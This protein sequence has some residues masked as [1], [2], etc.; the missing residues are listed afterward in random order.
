MVSIVIS[1]GHGQK[2][3]GASA[4]PQPPYLDEVN[5]ARKVVDRVGELLR[6]AGHSVKTYHENTATSVNQNL[7]NI[8]NYHNAQSRDRD[9]SVH[10]NAYSKT[11]KPMGTE[12]LY[13]TQSALADQVS[14]AMAGAG[15]FIN[16][17]PKK[18]TDLYFLNNT[19]KPSI[20]LEVCFV[21]SSADGDLYRANFDNLCR[22]IA[23]SCASIKLPGEEP[24]PIEP[25]PEPELPPVTGDH[26]AD[27]NISASKGTPG[28]EINGESVV[29]ASGSGGTVQMTLTLKGDVVVTVNGETWDITTPAPPTSQRPTIGK[30]DTGEQ[31]RVVQ[32]CLAIPVDG[33]FGSQTE[34]AV[35]NYQRSKGLAADGIVGPKT[36]TALEQDFQLPPYEPPTIA[37]NHS[38]IIC[39]VF[40]G[41][42]DPNDSA[43]PPYDFITD[44]ELS[45]A[46]PWKFTGARPSVLVI[47]D[48]NGKQV[49]CQIRDVGPWLID[50]DK[51]VLG[52]ARP[53]AEP[54]GSKIPRGKNK[55]K[56]SNGAGLDLTPAAARA[57]GLS[58][59]GKVSW[60]FVNSSDEVA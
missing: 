31:V 13:V 5:E 29:E 27:I 1:S 35:I 37:S 20:L 15:G 57:I 14:R 59:M 42:A 45:C 10:F 19:A 24:P 54:K 51:Y 38:D 46:L 6:N 39:S 36:W 44:Q 2:V 48:A 7:A 41:K 22:A 26:I 53:V 23:E 33:V 49:V 60:R 18:R 40:G 30:G 50:D 21:D 9:V 32:T 17:G 47:N 11:S 12:C 43:Y 56:T 16:R 55:G 58:G 52:D 25:P 3:R 8:V 4:S 34:S 28:L